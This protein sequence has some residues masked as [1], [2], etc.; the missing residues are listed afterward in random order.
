MKKIWKIN[1]KEGISL[2]LSVNSRKYCKAV[3]K[4]HTIGIGTEKIINE[5]DL[6]IQK[7]IPEYR[8]ILKV[9]ANS[10]RHWRT[11]EPG[12]LC[13][14]PWGR[15]EQ[16]RTSQLNNKKSQVSQGKVCSSHFSC[17]EMVRF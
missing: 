15:E 13:C 10:G 6:R 11:E 9:I 16:D 4:I 2:A 17:Y 3:L 8:R 5:T 14:S 12:V 1:V 7:K